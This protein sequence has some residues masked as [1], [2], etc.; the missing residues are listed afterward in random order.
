MN[1][2]RCTLSSENVETA[3]HCPC[4]LGTRD[5]PG[6]FPDH[7]WRSQVFESGVGYTKNR[8]YRRPFTSA[9]RAGFAGN[10]GVLLPQKKMG[11]AE[12]Q[13][14]AVLKGLLA[15]SSLS[16]LK[17]IFYHVLNSSPP[18]PAITIYMQIWTNYE[19]ATHIFKKWGSYPQPSPSWLRH[20]RSR[21][22][23]TQSSW[24]S[25]WSRLYFQIH[26][27]LY[28]KCRGLSLH[29]S[30]MFLFLNY[31]IGRSE[32]KKVFSAKMLIWSNLNYGNRSFQ[33]WVV[34]T[35]QTV[36]ILVVCL[37]QFHLNRRHTSDYTYTF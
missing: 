25:W 24:E 30:L 20:C 31:V 23:I 1:D 32:I 10:P 27:M 3:W 16:L 19:Y 22:C 33:Y 37:F 26:T 12:M 17:S 13:F 29:I 18:H 4:N 21:T 11:L 2:G 36:R 7:Q 9:V 14:P 5:S 35:T 28:I 34:G 15:L 8:T 6:R